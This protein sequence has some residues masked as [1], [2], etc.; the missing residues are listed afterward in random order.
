MKPQ[1]HRLSREESRRLRTVRGALAHEGSL[2]PVNA[3]SFL[4]RFHFL[5]LVFLGFWI[6]FSS[7]LPRKYSL[8]LNLS[9]TTRSTT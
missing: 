4:L 6:G 7:V 1:S 8:L 9:T 5:L 2:A 3:T